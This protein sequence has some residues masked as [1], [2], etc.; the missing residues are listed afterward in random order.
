MTAPSPRTSPRQASA[1]RARSRRLRTRRWLGAALV[2]VAAVPLLG[3][4]SAS[5]DPVRDKLVEAKLVAD[6][7]DVLRKQESVLA[8]EFDQGRL[9]VAAVEQQ[10][11]ANQRQLAS[12]RRDLAKRHRDLARFA[13]IAYMR[14]GD[15]LLSLVLHSG[16]GD[17]SA[18]EGY[19]T[20]TSGKKEQLLAAVKKAEAGSAAAADQLAQAR[21]AAVAARDDLEGKRKAVSALVLEQQQIV[22]RV[23]GELKLV[24]AQVELLRAAQAQAQALA[25]ARALALNAPGL[26][27]GWPPPIP[28]PG[29]AG[30]DVIPWAVS[31]IGL[32]YVWGAAGPSTFDCSGLVLWSW[33][34]AGRGSLP[35]SSAAMYAMSQ[36]LPLSALQPGDLVFF[37]SPVHHVGIYV[38]NAMMIDAMNSNTPVNYH[39]IY[40]LGEP[41]MGGRL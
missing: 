21:D 2:A 12:A 22:T 27:G 26:P 6:R 40:A 28:L 34:H 41:P 35:H 7:L 39:S 37:G 23:Q 10:V 31:R 32:P 3:S 15:D 9:R 29:T 33:A 18:S 20:A 16:N 19:L 24:V 13:A 36:H 30:A 1:S 11:A 38:G 17:T 4:T 14:G 5:G 25:A 8:E